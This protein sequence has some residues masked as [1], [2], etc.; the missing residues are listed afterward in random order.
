VPYRDAAHQRIAELDA[1]IAGEPDG[2]AARARIRGEHDV[3][4][5]RADQLALQL[6]GGEGV[7]ATV[8][9]WFRDRE[10]D[11]AAARTEHAAATARIAELVEAERAFEP[12][13]AAIAAARVELA[14][15]EA[16][17][18]VAL[19]EVAGGVGDELRALDAELAAGEAR[20]GAIEA[21]LDAIERALR[22]L[23]TLREHLASGS[24]LG[25]FAGIVHEGVMEALASPSEISIIRARIRDAIPFAQQWLRALVPAF[26]ALVQVWPAAPVVPAARLAS[27]AELPVPANPEEASFVRE[28]KGLA[29]RLEAIVTEAVRERDT[30][31]RRE[32]ALVEQQRTLVAD[33]L[34]GRRL[35]TGS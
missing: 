19:R 17:E 20:R 7:L 18:A 9:G 15:L 30:L 8:S 21:A 11:V 25:V 4:C 10:A 34:R 33:V 16:A 14:E 3:L 23:V 28:A 35:V 1:L 6:D 27:L 31:V 29:D 2:L 22:A 12:K 5:E 13:L 32:Q 26:A 24:R